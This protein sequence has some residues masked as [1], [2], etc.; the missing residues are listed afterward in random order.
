MGK[1]DSCSKPPTR[2]G[3]LGCFVAT[4]LESLEPQSAAELH[5]P[6]SHA[7][8]PAMLTIASSLYPTG[9]AGVE[10]RLNQEEPWNPW[11][12]TSDMKH[13]SNDCQPEKGAFQ[14]NN[15]LSGLVDIHISKRGKGSQVNY[16]SLSQLCCAPQIAK[17]VQN[18][19]SIH[20]KA[21]P[22]MAFAREKLAS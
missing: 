20:G 19:N 4:P 14:Q 8:E 12:H 1:E 10:Q 21:T 17:L 16:P 18:Y 2:N 6:C 7:R 5:S 15:C 11:N 22:M 9:A 13:T 3:L